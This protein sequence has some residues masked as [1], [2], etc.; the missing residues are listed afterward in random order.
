MKDSNLIDIEINDINSYNLNINK[1][2]SKIEN[3]NFKPH[4]SAA[5]DYCKFKFFC[6][7]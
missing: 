1:T 2:A 4:E 5:C 7:K 3:N 6:N